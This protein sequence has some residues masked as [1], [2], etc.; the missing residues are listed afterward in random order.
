MSNLGLEHALRALGL[1]FRRARVGDRYVMEMLQEG[2]WYLGGESSGHIICLDRTSTGDGIVS[3]LQVLEFMARSG[4]TLHE[5]KSGI[6]KYPQ[7]MVNVPLVAG[8]DYRASARLT[9]EL[10]G[11]EA[12]LGDSGRVLV[13]P[14]G[15]EA[16]LR[17]MVEG[18][19][20]RQ[21]KALANHL[22]GVV[23]AEQS[24]HPGVAGQGR[25]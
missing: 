6:T 7:H 3:A 13:R 20:A 24:A 22:G 4:C 18:V 25:D 10:R 12:S 15:T 1:E 21:V 11:A 5:L 17:I 8:F 16:L 2:G 19:D 14:S 23:A 9:T